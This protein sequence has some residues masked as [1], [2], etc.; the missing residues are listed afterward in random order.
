MGWGGNKTGTG[1]KFEAGTD[2]LSLIQT[3]PGYSIRNPE[4][5]AGTDVLFEGELVCRCFNGSGF[6]KFLKENKIDWKSRIS[7]KLIPDTVLLVIVRQTLFIVE[8]KCQWVNGSVD[9]KLQTCDFKRKQY[10]KLV[11]GLG[12]EVEYVY[13]LNEWFRKKRY[14]DA[15]RYITSVNCHYKFDEL[16]VK[17]LGLPMRAD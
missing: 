16:P 1:R 8:K 9:E 11:S 13:L 6:H 2:F 14:E 7:G 10:I 3:K 15:L 5:R 12:L 4:E 17:W